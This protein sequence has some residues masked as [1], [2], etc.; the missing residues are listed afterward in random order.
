MD[1]A[2]PAIIFVE[3]STT[4]DTRG[5]EHRNIIILSFSASP[6]Y[7][8]RNIHSKISKHIG[9]IQ[10]KAGMK[11]LHELYPHFEL[12]ALSYHFGDDAMQVLKL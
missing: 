12:Q 5:A 2:S 3:K 11:K 7:I 8:Q 9:I 6:M 10:K 4:M 1:G